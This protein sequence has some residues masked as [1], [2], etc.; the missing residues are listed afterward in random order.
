MFKACWSA[1]TAQPANRKEHGG[2][3]EDMED[4]TSDYVQQPP[5]RKDAVAVAVQMT[6]FTVF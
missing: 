2:F 6:L 1:H 4:L 3:N 5:L